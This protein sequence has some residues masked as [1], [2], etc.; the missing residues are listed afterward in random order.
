MTTDIDARRGRFETEL[1]QF[2]SRQEEPGRPD[3]D[4]DG[5]LQAKA[6]LA[7]LADGDRPLVRAIL[8]QFLR[9]GRLEELRLAA[10]LAWDLEPLPNSLADAWVR[11]DVPERARY[12]IGAAL[13]SAALRGDVSWDQRWATCAHL[14]G[15]Q[16]LLG[17]LLVFDHAGALQVMPAALGETKSSAGLTLH[18]ATAALNLNEY[19]AVRDELAQL[20]IDTELRDYLTAAMQWVID[21]QPPAAGDGRVRWLA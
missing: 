19:R 11:P 4:S 9:A 13:Q 3:F 6:W 7:E 17:A 5:V 15:G 2:A 1:R 12:Q 8:S 14:P 20:G 16:G 10:E 21:H 18:N